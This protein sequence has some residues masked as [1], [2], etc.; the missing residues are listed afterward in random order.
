METKLRA[1]LAAGLCGIQVSEL[2]RELGISRQTFYKYQRR[3]RAEGPSGLVERSRRPHRSPGLIDAAL[4]DEIVRLRKELPLDRG[5]QTIA[6]HLARSGWP[7]PSLSTIHRALVRRG[8]VVPEPHKR[9]RSSWRRFEW[10]RP[11]DAWQ[12]DATRWLLADGD[13]VWIMDLLDDHSRLALAARVCAGPSAAAAWGAFCD[14]TRY[15]GLPAHVM[16]DNGTCFYGTPLRRRGSRFRA[17][18][19]PPRGP[20]HPLQPWSSPDVREAGALPP[21]TQALARP[22]APG[23]DQGRAAGSAGRLPCLLQR[24][25]TPSGPGRGDPGRAVGRR[26]ASRARTADPRGPPR[27]P[28]PG[29]PRRHRLV[30]LPDRPGG[31]VLRATGAGHRPRRRRGRLRAHRAHPPS[32]ARP[33]PPLPA[34]GAAAG[35]VRAPHGPVLV[36]SA[37]S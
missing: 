10:P 4:E 32:Q 35:P 2:C 29:H 18:P 11:N 1:V 23:P 16:S 33:P 20:P 8:L 28:E 21:D 5:A 37:M 24:R 14:A 26:R 7:V 17:G 13:E 27:K 36:V 3:W 22:P 6:F 19:A 34:P 9:P 12:I 25:P 15:G 31:R 30:L